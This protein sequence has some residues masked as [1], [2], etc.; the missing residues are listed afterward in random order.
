MDVEALDQ[1]REEVVAHVYG[2]KQWLLALAVTCPRKEDP[3]AWRREVDQLLFDLQIDG[4]DV[5]IDGRADQGPWI[6]RYE[7]GPGWA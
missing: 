5:S 4:V 3:D 6:R 1:L 2:Q 7:L